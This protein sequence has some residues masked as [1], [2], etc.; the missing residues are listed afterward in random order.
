MASCSRPIAAYTACGGAP[1]ASSAGASHMSHL[2]RISV[3][4]RPRVGISRCLLGDLVRYDGGHK[5]EPDL[6]EALGRVVE[7]VSVCPEVEVGMG[8]PREPVRLMARD[9]PGADGCAP[10]RLVGVE[11]GEDW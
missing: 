10:I 6:V 3:A 11:T 1:R 7:W 8:V 9:G 4:S 5:R 2:G